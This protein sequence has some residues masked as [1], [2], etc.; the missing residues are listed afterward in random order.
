MTMNQEIPSGTDP[1]LLPTWRHWRNA[2]LKAL[3]FAFFLIFLALHFADPIRLTTADL[4][5]H[6]KNGEMILAGQK[7]VMTTNFY[8]YTQSD[9]P[10][11]NHH[12]AS[13]VLFYLVYKHGGGFT[14]L[15]FFYLG[16]L[17]LTFFVFFRLAEKFSDFSYAMF[18]SVVALPIFTDR[19]EIRPEGISTLFIGIYLYLLFL[20]R[21][22]KISF[23]VLAWTITILQI[24]WVNIHIFFFMGGFF[25]VTFF[26]DAWLGRQDKTVMK[27][28]FILGVLVAAASLL[29]PAGIK[30]A[31]VPLTIFKQYGYRLAENQSVFFMQKRFHQE[32]KYSYFEMLFALSLAGLA[33]AYWKKSWRTH[34]APVLLWGFFAVLG[35]KTVRSMAMFGFLFIPLSGLF[36]YGWTER[37]FPKAKRAVSGIM[38]AIALLVVARG[39]VCTESLFSP[40]RRL[41]PFVS[42]DPKVQKERGFFYLLSHPEVWSG[43][44]PGVNE[45]AYFYKRTGLKG[46]LFNNYDIGGYLIFHL[47]PQTRVFVDNRPEVY[48]VSFFKDMY[49]PMQENDEVWK[50]MDAQYHFNVIYFY[51]YDLTPWGQ[52]FM[53]HRIR[54]PEWA[55]VFVDLYSII[56]LKRNAQN[57]PIIDAFELPA[58]MFKVT[59]NI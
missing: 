30:G 17:L 24:A 34:L 52:T 2:F 46:P 11:V 26:I 32:F 40:Y 35:F 51:R 7:G 55:P 50:K 10:F 8:S 39:V 3:A 1:V 19:L 4:G 38:L 14:G 28:L 44:T 29:N 59:G 37:F 56:F 43:L 33:A 36:W 48:S 20:Y 21:E 18:F 49:V 15:S 6:L 13:G 47:F 58:S 9:F 53:I 41:A 31:L 25:V 23:P 57:K 45:S 27:E 5:R 42:F 22:R 16:I 54:D 12:W